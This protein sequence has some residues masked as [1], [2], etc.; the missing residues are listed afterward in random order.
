MP[1][2]TVFGNQYFEYDKEN[3]MNKY[4]ISPTPPSNVRASDNAGKSYSLEWE[5]EF[6]WDGEYIFNV[7]ADLSLIHIS[8]PTRPY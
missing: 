4:A 8:E 5:E 6:P 7:Q 1:A 2:K 3:F